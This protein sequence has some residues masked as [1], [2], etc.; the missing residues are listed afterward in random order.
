L[1]VNPSGRL[2]YT[3]GK[4]RSDYPADVLCELPFLALLLK[5]PRLT[6]SYHKDTNNSIEVPQIPYSEELEIDYRW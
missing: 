5:N 1:T 4:K 3:I 2:P 6:S